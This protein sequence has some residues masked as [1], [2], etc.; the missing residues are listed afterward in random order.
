MSITQID[1]ATLAAYRRTHYR[2]HA[3]PPFTLR[4][5]EFS[6]PLLRLHDDYG[7]RCSAY[8]TAC[9]PAGELHAA[10]INEQAQ[11]A[12]LGDLTME[13]LAVIEGVGEGDGKWPGEASFLV[14]GLEEPTARALGRKYRQ[15]AILW[16]GV[17]AIPRL[18]LLR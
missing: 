12:L 15:N 5:D 7:V 3:N 1:A 16:A 17:D 11:R 14:L 10:H 13:G 9:N 2:V 4:V 6:A 8:I 18:V